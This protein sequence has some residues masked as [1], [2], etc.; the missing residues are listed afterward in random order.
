MIYTI[1]PF[2]KPMTGEITDSRNEPLVAVL[3]SG[4]ATPLSSKY[5]CLY[6]EICAALSFGQRC[7][8]LSAQ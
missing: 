6:P 2:K 1:K 5:L 4:Y 7:S 3:L 8:F